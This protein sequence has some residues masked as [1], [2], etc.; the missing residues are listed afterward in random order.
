MLQAVALLFTA[1][2]ATT[3]TAA[4]ITNPETIESITR[5]ELTSQP[6]ATVHFQRLPRKQMNELISIRNDS[7]PNMNYATQYLY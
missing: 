5:P 2:L 7:P 3:S 6:D 1:L 4:Y